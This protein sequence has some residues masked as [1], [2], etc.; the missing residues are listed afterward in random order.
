MDDKKTQN[1]F[2]LHYIG[3]EMYN[4]DIF[5]REA[6]KYRVQR[7]VAFNILKTFKWGDPVLLAR[8]IPPAKIEAV[9][10]N[11]IPKNLKIEQVSLKE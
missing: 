3:Q 10:A 1:K 7:A 5:E 6:K 4:T 2:R 11:Q 9:E 8:Y